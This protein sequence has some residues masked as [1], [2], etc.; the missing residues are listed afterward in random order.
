MSLYFTVSV[1]PKATTFAVFTSNLLLESIHSGIF[2]ADNNQKCVPMSR[3]VCLLWFIA[4]Y[5]T[6]GSNKPHYEE[7]NSHPMHNP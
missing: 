2:L 1:A 6:A 7:C 5:K 4:H 3:L